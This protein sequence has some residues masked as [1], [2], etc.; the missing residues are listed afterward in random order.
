MILKLTK[1][2]SG[3]PKSVDVTD[4]SRVSHSC[5]ASVCG[6]DG[7]FRCFW[8]R[9]EYSDRR[10]VHCPMNYHPKQVT[11]TFVSKQSGCEYSIK[12]NVDPE[13]ETSLQVV[14]DE[15]YTVDGN[16]CSPECCL[17]EILAAGSDV[18]YSRAEMLFRKIYGASV[19]PA[20][21]WRTLVENGGTLTSWCGSVDYSYQGYTSY[22]CHLYRPN[23]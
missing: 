10:P 16:Y 21:H 18:A 2:L 17:A 4:E 13:R 7:P 6:R 20:P 23:K 12:G 3:A 9:R 8:C 14:N 19:R 22:T 5:M 1:K 11:Q 15:S